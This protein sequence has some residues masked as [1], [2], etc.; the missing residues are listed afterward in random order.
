MRVTTE[1]QFQTAIRNVQR[2]A[3]TMAKLQ[4]QLASG[5][6]L[7]RPSDGPAEVAQLQRAKQE[8]ARLSFHMRTI[9]DASNVLDTS[10]SALTNAK[11]VLTR[12]KD[13]ALE[14]AN[15]ATDI[16]G[17]EAFAQE[18]DVAITQLM[19]LANQRLPDGRYLFAGTASDRQPYAVAATDS[20]G[21]PTR[22]EYAGGEESSQ[23]LVGPG[24]TM[25][26]LISGRVFQLQQRARTVFAGS[27]GA[28]PG[29][30][31]DSASGQ[32]TLL[33]QHT[34]TT[35]SGT[36]GISPGTSSNTND[37]VIGPDGANLLTI[38][39][40]AKT[41]SL[42]GGTPVT[43]DQTEADLKV[44]G[45]KGESVFVNTTGILDGFVGTES[46][47]A[48]GS[49][50]IDGGATSVPID[51]SSNQVLTNTDGFVTNIDSSNIR[52]AGTERLDYQGTESAFDALTALRDDI[53]NTGNMTT[54]ERN[55]ALTRRLEELD[56]VI[57]GV[58]NALGSQGVQAE[59]LAQ[60]TS[61][62]EDVQLSLQKEVDDLESVDV[63]DALTRLTQQENLFQLSLSLITR[64]NQLDLSQF[65]R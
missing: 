56:R 36:S 39:N 65:L 12:A 28:K 40:V 29:S 24:Q 53:R 26:T 31:T 14:A 27:T 54:P 57:G 7:R 37:T 64:M 61:R 1:S 62:N 44:T 23:V 16:G 63:A 48:D 41:I 10:T 15:T 52:L 38:D 20:A 25:D 22:I 46:I 35:Y 32:G 17:S 59:F 30:G 43:F 19:Q 34:S 6:R 5:L 2:N 47:L 50:S 51:F 8:D 45:P 49:I 9:R 13:I 21:R 18:I 55:A 33:V 11:E 4:D 3:T 42:N 58:L 60:L